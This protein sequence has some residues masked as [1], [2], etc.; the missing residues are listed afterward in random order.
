MRTPFVVLPALAVLSSARAQGPCVGT[1]PISIN[2]VSEPWAVAGSGYDAGISVDGNSVSLQHDFRAYLVNGSAS[3]C[4]SQ[5]HSSMF[6]N[7]LQL[8]GATLSVTVDISAFGCGCNAGFY[9]VSMPG[10]NAQGQPDPSQAGDYYCDANMVGGTWCPEIDLLE[11]NTAAAQI[12]PHRCDPPVNGYYDSCDKGGCGINTKAQPSSFG[13]GASFMV[14]SSRPFNLST[15][16]ATDPATGQLQTM[17]SV[18]SQAGGGAFSIV[19]ADADCS[20]PQYLE[21]LTGALK[22]GMVLTMSVWGDQGSSM[23]WL[24]VP[25]CDPNAS[26]PQSNGPV[27]RLSAFSVTPLSSSHL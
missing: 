21:A 19:H 12:T 3:A 13:P 5:F 18:F 27:M 26:C 22:G 6:D 2:G 10:M 16:F 15:S 17:T 14:D 9:L 8:L 7:K 11:S 20:S 1:L 23:S 4:P 24:D 25:P